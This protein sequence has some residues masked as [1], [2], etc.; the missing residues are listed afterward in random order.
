MHEYSAESHD[1]DLTLRA[2]WCLLM[3]GQKALAHRK[4]KE[5]AEVEFSCF[6]GS[7][8]L[9]FCAIE[10]FSASIAFSMPRGNRFQTFDYA[11]YEKVRNFWPKLEM[12]CKAIPYSIDRSDGL[13]KTIGEMQQW[14][15]RVTHAAPYAIEKT[16]IGKTVDSPTLHKPFHDREYTRRVNVENAKRFYT[17][18][19]EYVD[20]MRGLTGL[21]PRAQA[22]Y[23]IGSAKPT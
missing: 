15:N 6:T 16:A 11:K 4:P 8:L 20:L 22:S 9:S 7:M 2:A 17:A 14:R 10:S 13:F 23:K 19:Y 18:A 12:L 3:A 1:W 5:S 21:E